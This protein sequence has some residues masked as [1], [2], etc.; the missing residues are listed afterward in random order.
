MDSMKKQSLLKKC[1]IGINKSIENFKTIA[2]NIKKK[3]FKNEKIEKLNI[4]NN[5]NIN[6]NTKRKK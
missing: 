6:K 1:K 4:N 3:L 5:K 2:S